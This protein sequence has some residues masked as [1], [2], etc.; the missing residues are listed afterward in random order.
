MLRKIANFIDLRDV[1]V[2]GGA[3]AVLYGVAQIYSP[4]AW[5]IGG[6]AFVLIGLRK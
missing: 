5:I 1:I 3:A 2:I 4:A 6:A